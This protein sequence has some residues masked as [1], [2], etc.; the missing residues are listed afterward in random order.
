MSKKSAAFPITD[1]RVQKVSYVHDP[2]AAQMWQQLLVE[3]LRT[4]LAEDMNTTNIEEANKGDHHEE[5]GRV[6]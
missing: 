2:K 6:L 4:E 5:D 1:I 3:I